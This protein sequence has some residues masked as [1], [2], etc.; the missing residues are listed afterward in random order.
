MT[1]TGENKKPVLNPKTLASITEDIEEDARKQSDTRSVHSNS[2]LIHSPQIESSFSTVHTTPAQ[3]TAPE[4]GVIE[5]TTG[6]NESLD[7]Q[8]S[9]VVEESTDCRNVEQAEEPEGVKSSSVGE[10]RT[11]CIAGTSKTSWASE[12]SRKRERVNRLKKYGFKTKGHKCW[13]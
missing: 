10:A 4:Q 2:P 6:G 8:V 3:P 5:E 1:S 12:R 11:D 7:M 9:P 13:S